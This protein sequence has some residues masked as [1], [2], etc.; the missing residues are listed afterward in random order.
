[1][2]G[3][4]IYGNAPYRVVV[5]CDSL[6]SFTCTGDLCNKLARKIGVLEYLQEVYTLE[7]VIEELEWLIKQF[8]SEKVILIGHSFGAW[9]ALLFAARHAEMI[10]KVIAIG[11]EPLEEAHFKMINQIRKVRRTQGWID[12]DDYCVLSHCGKGKNRKEWPLYSVEKELRQLCKSGKLLRQV[13]NV[14]CPVTFLF[15]AFDPRPVQGV[16]D[17]LKGKLKNIRVIVLERC[18]H[19]PWKERY[20]EDI[21]FETMFLEIGCA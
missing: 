20:A 13:L 17:P 4:K 9:V 10:S 1:M 6:D 18:G 14:R 8:H 16:R 11:C 3:V 15:G 5:L 2:K 19:S 12:T 21:F 7:A